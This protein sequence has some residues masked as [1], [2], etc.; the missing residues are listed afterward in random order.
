MSNKL[1]GWNKICGFTYAQ[2]MKS[3]AMKITLAILCII[4][5]VSMPVCSLISGGDDEDTTAET[6][7]ITK[8]YYYD[9]TGAIAEEFAKG[10]IQEDLY[11]DIVYEKAEDNSSEYIDKLINR[12]D[13]DSEIFL[14]IE[15]GEKPESMD[16]GVSVFT[17]YN[18]DS[19]VE[20]SDVA[21][22]GDFIA[23]NVEKAI[24]MSHDV[25]DE[26][27]KILLKDI[28]TEV[29]VFDEAG[30]PVENS[31]SISMFQYYFTLTFICIM[32]FIVSIVGGKVSELIVTE[33]STRVMEYLLTSVKPMAVLVGKVI[34]STLIML[35]MVGAIIVSLVASVFL[36]NY[37]FPSGDG[38]FALPGVI[39][40][41]VDS[42]AI[43][44]ATIPNIILILIIL[45]LGTV[46]YGFIAGIAGA[47]VS[48][49][50]EMAEGMKIYTFAMLIGAYL[51]LIMCMG[52]AMGSGEEGVFEY[53][54]YF[55]PLSSVF[56]L[57]QYLLMGRVEAYIVLIAIA[58]LI[59]A[60]MLVLLLVNKI[61]EHM[62][63]SNDTKLS[64]KD[65]ISLTKK[66]K[67]TGDGR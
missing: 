58:L 59:A 28:S 67:V 61:Y 37:M 47:M 53:V 22:Y 15:Y 41:L 48:K 21:D 62:L 65:I 43:V 63:Y 12:E 33:K 19:D 55:L 35:T 46:F 2:S 51:P 18:E 31:E 49:I 52:S 44:A 64:V 7:D 8:V 16:Y 60:I 36:D 25:N 17:Y 32:I 30:T 14:N 39:A 34:G 56:I 50:E 3:K 10:N 38:S 5:L 23:E 20:K 27:S 54:V 4:A 29:V 66:G 45:V 6:T 9:S 13:N 57:P 11:K 1:I 42:G 26:T 40:D 24:L